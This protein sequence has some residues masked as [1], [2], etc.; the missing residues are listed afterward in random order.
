MYL[1]QDFISDIQLYDLLCFM[2]SME[3]NWQ[4]CLSSQWALVPLKFFALDLVISDYILILS[5]Y[6]VSVRLIMTVE[7]FF[8]KKNFL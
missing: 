6:Y 1:W 5:F 4:L 2:K 8:L 7:R 3:E